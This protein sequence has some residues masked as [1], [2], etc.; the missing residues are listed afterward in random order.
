MK[1][2]FSH[3]IFAFI[4]FFFSIIIS[5]FSSCSSSRSAST[6]NLSHIYKKEQAILHPKY[7]VF[8]RTNTTS[9][10]HFSINSKELLYS[11]QSGSETFTARINIHYRLISSYETKDIID[12]ATVALSDS[13]SEKSKNIIGKI[14][15]NATFTNTYLLEINFTDVNR[16]TTSKSFISIDKLNFGTRQN[17]IILSAETKTPIFRDNVSKNERIFLRYKTPNSKLHVRYYHRDFPLPAPPFALSNV[18]PFEYKADS[19][20]AIFLDEKDTSGFFF[21]K[22]GFYHIQADTNSKEGL[23]VFQFYNDFPEIKSPDK[24]LEPLRYLTSKQEYESISSNANIKHAVDSFWVYAG[25]SHERARELVRKYYNRVR[26]ANL[27]FSSF[28]EGW[29]TD[30]G[31]IYLIY[32]PPNVVY[33]SSDSE[34]WV[35]GEE[36]NFNS[37]TFSFLKVINPFTDNDYR[38]ERSQVFKTG[39]FN[40][41]EMWRQGRIY[42]EK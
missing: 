34:N 23:T 25:G 12:S 13:Y 9:E 40:A 15:F 39:W 36:N 35:Y 2:Y 37:L 7:V 17:F 26:D 16:N 24:L 14:D 3:I 5:L 21:T 8:H 20:F 30:R 6:Q 31:L 19:L 32:G 42:A 41:V 29:K 33:K 27:Y 28:V 11:K 4:I 22:P 18:T 38:L 1:K 10:L